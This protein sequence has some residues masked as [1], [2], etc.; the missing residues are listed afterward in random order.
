MKIDGPG[1]GKFSLTSDF[2]SWDFWP[3]SFNGP[4]QD[5][6]GPAGY[7]T[8]AAHEIEDRA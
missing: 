8:V 5:W 1:S 7:R 3:G 6:A 4:S 2:G